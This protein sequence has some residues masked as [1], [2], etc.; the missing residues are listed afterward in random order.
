MTTGH[1]KDDVEL[2]VMS[3]YCMQSN[4]DVLLI[5]KSI[6][7]KSSS[8]NKRLASFLTSSPFLRVSAMLI[9]LSH[10]RPSS[11]H[12]PPIG[13]LEQTRWVRGRVAYGPFGITK[14]LIVRAEPLGWFCQAKCAQRPGRRRLSPNGGNFSRTRMT[15]S[16]GGFQMRLEPSFCC[17]CLFAFNNCVFA[18]Q[19]D[20]WALDMQPWVRVPRSDWHLY[21]MMCL[22][23][24]GAQWRQSGTEKDSCPK[25]QMF[26]VFAE[27]DEAK[28]PNLTVSMTT[29]YVVWN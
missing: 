16:H 20:N 3:F 12:L 29:S 6:N 9:I 15:L 14:V 13:P 5:E 28:P 22:Q 19:R 25:C 8:S 18:A 11:P 7:K 10:A 17:C 23:F 24:S 26:H 27:E 1:S 21:C 2:H 4:R